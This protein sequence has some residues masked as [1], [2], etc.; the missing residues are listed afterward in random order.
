MSLYLMGTALCLFG[1]LLV[2]MGFFFYANIVWCV[3]NPI[4]IYRFFMSG[5][6]DLF[7]MQSIFFIIAIFGV[8]N[9]WKKN[10]K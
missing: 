2:S 8:I 4:L 5:D 6:T 7:I 10:V 3:G 1:A 9:L